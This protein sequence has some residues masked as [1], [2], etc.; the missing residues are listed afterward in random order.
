LGLALSPLVATAA[1]VPLMRAGVELR[2]SASVV[3]AFGIVLIAAAELVRRRSPGMRPAESPRR[4]DAPDLHGTPDGTFVLLWSLALAAV[5]AIPPL[6]NRYVPVRGDAWTHAGI[7][8]EIIVRGVPPEDPRFAGLPINYVWFFHAFLALL[9]RLSGDGPFF[10]MPLFNVVQGG[11]TASLAY[12]IGLGLW[13][14]RRA[15]R[16][17]LLLVVLGFN[18]ASYLLWPLGFIRPLIGTVRSPEELMAYIH[19][20]KFPSAEIIFS[21]HAG[22]ASMVNFFDKL[23]TG[24]AIHHGY[25]LMMVYLWASLL[26][27]AD[28][29]AESLVLV[30]AAAAGMLFFHGVVGLSVVPVALATLGALCLARVRWSWLPPAGRLARLVV[31]TGAGALPAV[32][33][34]LAISR[35]WAHDKSGLTQSY[36]AP[37]G[38]ALWTL[39][40]ASGV[41][42]WLAREPIRRMFRERLSEPAV[43]LTLALG[44]S[45]F[46]CVVRLPGGNETKFVFEAFLPLAALGGAALLDRLARW[47]RRLGGTGFALAFAIVFLVNPIL[48]VAG[49]AL[50]PAGRA[51]PELH[52]RP[53]EE[54]LYGW[55]RKDTPARA[56]FVDAK[57]RDLIM[58]KGQRELYVGTDSGPEKAAFPAAELIRR[59]TLIADVYGDAIGWA[60]HRRALAVLGRPIYVLYRPED[61]LGREPWRPLATDGSSRLVYDRDGYRVY[62]LRSPESSP[63][64]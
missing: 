63:P 13:R 3:V 45:V 54:A 32:P 38:T 23:L 47:R 9:V 29:R 43:V 19:V 60:E 33:Y 15:A 34:T 52:P 62:A 27:L 46:A 22:Y 4:A 2:S 18:A 12:R 48:T 5:V 56:V 44:L 28:G 61:A 7:V 39:L 35:G 64:R 8:W 59:R 25:L 53:G 51:R 24:T 41:A 26:W 49:F 30:A 55:I 21:L 16:G 58:V 10:F 14:D 40:T 17:T 1:A 37:N 11:L 20:V 6:V 31:A 57:D 50:D 36:W 42:L